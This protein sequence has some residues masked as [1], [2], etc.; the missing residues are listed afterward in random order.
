MERSAPS[1]LVQLG[2][3]VIVSYSHEKGGTGKERKKLAIP[4]PKAQQR[5]NGDGGARL[6]VDDVG[7]LVQPV[8]PIGFGILG[9]ILVPKVAVLARSSLGTEVALLVSLVLL[10]LALGRDVGRGREGLIV[11]RSDGHGVRSSR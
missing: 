2:R 3:T 9:G 5:R 11:D 4:I 6:T 10:R 1:V 7:V 8:G